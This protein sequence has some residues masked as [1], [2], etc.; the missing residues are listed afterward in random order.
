M[1][2]GEEKGWILDSGASQHLCSQQEVFVLGSYRLTQARGIEIA[3][4]SKIV[5]VGV[6]DVSIGQLQLTNVLHVPRV[7]GNLISVARLIDSGYE[8]SFGAEACIITK[9]DLR[10]TAKR[11]GNLY[12]L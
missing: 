10:V 7:G 5:A 8:V 3:N 12:Y 11:E 4:G 9:K 1:R 2:K 6:G